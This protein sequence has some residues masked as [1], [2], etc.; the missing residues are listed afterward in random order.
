MRKGGS[1]G[2]LAT[3]EGAK[4]SHPREQRKDMTSSLSGSEMQKW[5]VEGE[6]E[7]R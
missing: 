2:G 7:A 3:G 5:R 1:G 4:G 6:M